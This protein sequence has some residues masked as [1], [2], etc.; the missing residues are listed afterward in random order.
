[1]YVLKT[2]EPTVIK[3]RP[4]QS[5]E[6]PD[7]QKHFLEKDTVLDIHS[8]GFERDHIKVAFAKDFFN[9]FNTWYVYR[10]HAQILSNSKVLFP[11]TIPDV[12][13][14]PIPYK[15]Q[16]DNIENPNGSCNVTSLAMCLEFLGAS[17][18]WQYSVRYRQFEDE[19]YQYAIDHRLSRHDPHDLAVIV[20]K[21][22]CRDD[23]QRNAT[24]DKV[25]FWLSQGKP[26]VVHGYFTSFGHIVV[27]AGFD[28][29]GFLVHDP[30]GEWNSWG[31]D[32][33]VPGK[34]NE[35]G[36]YIHYSYNLIRRVC[37]PDGDF[38][39]HFISK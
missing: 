25:K 24:I 39:V 6:L 27:L 38:W 30:Y 10:P 20:E 21:Y 17:R 11:A 35:K 37:M 22:G 34:S 28:K 31:Y 7:D 13:K 8:Y 2:I 32:R 12:V 1:M 18:K 5:S 33:N 9:G 29:N 15:S 4:L 16:V 36:K 3:R 19:L 14:L 23:F 26:A